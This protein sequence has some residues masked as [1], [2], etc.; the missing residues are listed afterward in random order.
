MAI[1]ASG[2]KPRPR[3]SASCCSKTARSNRRACFWSRRPLWRR[4]RRIKSATAGSTLR[5]N[6]FR[7]AKDAENQ[8]RGDLACALAFAVILF[9]FAAGQASGRGRAGALPAAFRTENGGTAETARIPSRWTSGA[10]SGCSAYTFVS[11]MPGAKTGANGLVWG[12]HAGRLH[13]SENAAFDNPLLSEKKNGRFV[14]SFG[15]GDGSGPRTRFWRSTRFIFI[16]LRLRPVP[17]ARRPLI[18]GSPGTASPGSGISA[19]TIP[20]T[21]RWNIWTGAA[22]CPATSKPWRRLPS[23]T[24]TMFI[25]IRL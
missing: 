25:F 23:S 12:H 10:P 24:R 14:T 19:R 15:D 2:R 9:V 4:K 16:F 13:C 3:P 20:M 5:S 11:P 6:N 17:D 8:K 21:G 22:S 7:K 1:W 18:S